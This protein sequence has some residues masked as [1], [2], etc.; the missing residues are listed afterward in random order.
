VA[1]AGLVL[2]RV[3]ATEASDACLLAGQQLLLA[4]PT[5][6]GQSALRQAA[7]ALLRGGQLRAGCELLHAW[8]GAAVQEAASPDAAQPLASGALQQLMQEVLPEL[9]V[10][11]AAQALPLDE[12][13]AAHEAW[14]AASQQGGGEARARPARQPAERAA[15]LGT[16][17][18]AEG[19]ASCCRAWQAA[20]PGGWASQ[21]QAQQQVRR[22]Q[23]FAATCPGPAVPAGG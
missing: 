21:L 16:G 13:A 4:K 23:L 1:T 11:G 10:S 2:Q 14:R 8:H 19:L 18:L 5:A 15:Q 20:Q 17:L 7:V 3:P 9:A 12:L 6:A 22:R